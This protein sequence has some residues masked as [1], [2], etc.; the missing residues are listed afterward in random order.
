MSFSATAMQ[1]T[2]LTSSLQKKPMAKPYQRALLEMLPQTPLVV[3]SEGRQNPHESINDLP[4]HRSTLL[5][6]FYP[7]SESRHFTREDAGKVFARS[8]LPADARIPHPDMIDAAA[9]RASGMPYSERETKRR[10]RWDNEMTAR[11]EARRRD[12]E[13]R[14]RREVVVP[15]QRYDFKFEKI[16]VDEGVGRNERSRR[17]IGW[18]YGFPLQDRKKGRVVIPTSVE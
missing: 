8:L 14:S 18:R 6:L 16:A 15:G 10:E 9:D 3:A 12:E 17:G 11:D 1:S 4:V 5:Q 7:T 2:A 13:R